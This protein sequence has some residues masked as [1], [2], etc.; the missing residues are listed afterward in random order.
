MTL[1]I[2]NLRSFRDKSFSND[3]DCLNLLKVLLPLIDQVTNY[4]EISDIGFEIFKKNK[5]NEYLKKHLLDTI[6]SG[7][8]F[9]V[10]HFSFCRKLFKS[11]V[12]I[13]IPD[14]HQKLEKIF[15]D[16][17]ENK[18]KPPIGPDFKCII[19]ATPLIFFPNEIQKE[20]KED[21]TKYCHEINDI[22]H[23]SPMIKRM[24]LQWPTPLNIRNEIYGLM[25]EKNTFNPDDLEKVINMAGDPNHIPQVNSTY[26][27]PSKFLPITNTQFG[28]TSIGTCTPSVLPPSKPEV[29]D[30]PVIP[31]IT[32]DPNYNQIKERIEEPTAIVV[33]QNSEFYKL[34]SNSTKGGAILFDK[35]RVNCTI[36]NCKFT[37]CIG[38]N[39]GAI[40]IQYA[41]DDNY[42]SGRISKTTF[43]NCFAKTDG[44]AINL[45]ITQPNRHSFVIEEC[46]FISNTAGDQGGA[47]Y[48][49]AR[50]KLTI[51]K[52]TFENNVA[53]D[54]EKQG[55]SLYASIG[56]TAKGDKGNKITLLD[57][58]FSF[59]PV[60]DAFNVYITTT[61][62]SNN[63]D[64]KNA[65]LYIG[66]CTFSTP[67]TPTV[68]FNHLKIYEQLKY[69]SIVF[70]KCNCVQ[71]GPD[72]VSVPD[73][74]INN[75]NFNCDPNGV[76]TPGAPVT[77]GPSAKPDDDGYT[78]TDR[79]DSPGSALELEKAKFTDIKSEGKQG[80]AIRIAEP[81]VDCTIINCK[82]T[83][84]TAKTGGA[85]YISYTHGSTHELLIKKTIF[86]DC[87][88]TENGG[89]L[90]IYISQENTH[91][92]TI[93]ECTFTS[94]K[95]GYNGGA[96]Y[97]DTR[98]SFILKHCSFDGNQ[99]K[100]GSSLW[101]KVGYRSEK[102]P[103]YDFAHVLSN[104]FTFTP[105]GEESNVYIR[106]YKLS[107]GD[108]PNANLVLS[109][110]S[111]TASNPT[112]DIY[113]NLVIDDSEGQFNSISFTSWNC[114]KQG[115]N[116][117]TVPSNYKLSNFKFECND[118]NSCGPDSSGYNLHDQIIDQEQPIELE[119]FKFLYHD[120][121]DSNGGAISVNKNRVNCTITKCIFDLCASQY[122]GAVYIKYSGNGTYVCTI[123]SSEFTNCQATTH[124][125]AIFIQTTQSARHTA[126]VTDCKFS[127]NNAKSNGGAIYADCRDGFTLK[128]CVFTD[129][130]ATNNGSSLWCRVGWNDRYNKNEAI[131]QD[132]EFTFTPSKKTNVNVFIS[133]YTLNI[134]VTPNANLIF[135]GCTFNSKAADIES[136]HLRI[137]QYR[138]QFEHINF[139]SCSCVKQGVDTVDLPLLY[140]AEY[141]F[142]FECQD[143]GSCT[144]KPAS[145]TPTPTPDS[146][147]YYVSD[148]RFNRV[149]FDP[150]VVLTRVK[151]SNF[152]PENANYYG[153]AIYLNKVPGL[154]N[155]CKFIKCQSV[156]G[157]AIY[158]GY[159]G[160]YNNY[161]CNIYST[162]FEN[163]NSTNGGAIYVSITQRRR[164]HVSLEGCTFT[165]NTAV[166]NG[167]AIYATVRDCFSVRQSLFVNNKAL[168]GS[169]VW[170][171]VGQDQGNEF[172]DTAVFYGNNFTFTPSQSNTNNVYVQ[173]NSLKN[174]TSPNANVIF[175]KNVFTT[176]DPSAQNY[177]HLEIRENGKFE[178]IQFTDCNCI[179]GLESSIDIVAS[180][181]PNTDNLIYNCTSFDQCPSAGEKPPTSDQCNSERQESFGQEI[182]IENSCFSNIKAPVSVEGGAVRV[183]NAKLEAEDCTF[184]NCSSDSN[185][186]AIYV[187]FSANNCELELENCDFIT[188]TS[189]GSGGA[190]Y[191]INTNPS[192]ES[193][194][195][196]CKFENNQAVTSGGA[197]YYSPCANSEMKK[198]LFI[199][200]TCTS[201]KAQGT[202]LYAFISNQEQVSS[203]SKN[204]KMIKDD[205]NEVKPVVIEGNRF[206]SEPVTQTQQLFINLKKSGQ[207]EFNSNSF[208]FNKAEEIP[209]G[210][211]YIQLQKDEGAVL[212]VKDDI[213]VD[214]K[215]SLVSGFDSDVNIQTDCHVA[216]PE[217][218]H[219][220][221]GDDQGG[222]KKNN[223]G[224]I[225]GVTVA[226]VVV[227]AIIVVVVVFVVLRKKQGNYVSDLNEDE[228]ADNNSGTQPTIE[229]PTNL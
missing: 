65:N 110:C 214:N 161:T 197:F 187:S 184:T 22:F 67:Q 163:C 171:Q 175:G 36:D 61:T 138:S 56:C 133:S 166:T 66:G 1:T 88:S 182:S 90:Y 121:D 21:Y 15:S 229:D 194:F 8:D 73:I 28:C 5:D 193:S 222:K 79:I 102:D 147:G 78:K 69:E 164:H 195:E 93:K 204:R 60:Q 205:E 130:V 112:S 217:N 51:Q 196:R 113:K 96:I 4:Y 219:E 158:V 32:P 46:T 50:D 18:L 189:G 190:I 162:I 178:A 185:G 151:F 177:K 10:L 157:G 150:K 223:V 149:E 81:V 191:F 108:G 120:N 142:T 143:L 192:C 173:S 54:N 225:V 154:I 167:G 83:S 134:D 23:H 125:G 208:S 224:L 188:C 33:V 77:P 55:F 198:N 41:G 20:F 144:A 12:M 75:F 71:Q 34:G 129:N 127:N 62:N 206:R 213:C 2:E 26:T 137:Y 132:N 16:I 84:C 201:T 215:E 179:Q 87:S 128:N 31:E 107:E 165:E 53:Y 85:M 228:V 44:G 119:N 101:L 94:N 124:G 200:N 105:S 115:E 38:N 3:G 211:K 160:S 180:V 170:C 202:S 176:V 45:K 19:L 109:L 70:T 159:S 135:G 39:G 218:D 9:N 99:A 40:W 116:T 212:A 76:C 72:T 57:N 123:T 68:K 59:T 29:P 136:T 92:A 118:I 114:V 199:N 181:K 42:L 203:F 172:G 7:E 86:T 209:S 13:T 139:T 100:I 140:N 17:R 95:A 168:N 106:S 210:A 103:T 63:Y 156:R 145:P 169:S 141:Y 25:D 30:V 14:V 207:L 52:C 216:D 104:S 43:T 153:G 49:E 221:E 47:I 152:S 97:A 74:E 6:F 37:Y 117:V 27:I 91:S 80:G 220:L 186:G 58:K 126:T 227:V 146:E 174:I 131:I 89:A 82:F 183:V 11:N 148:K 226:A 35:K 122:G 64:Y 24:A 155:D 111:F 98:D 48:T